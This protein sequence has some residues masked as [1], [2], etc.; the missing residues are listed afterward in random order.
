[1]KR[2]GGIQFLSLS[3]TNN[4]NILDETLIS[5]L[6]NLITSVDSSVPIVDASKIAPLFQINQ[7]Q[8][9]VFTFFIIIFSKT[10]KK[11]LLFKVWFNNKGWPA[12]VAFLNVF[13]NALLRGILLE[14]NSLNSLDDYGIT[15]IS[16]PLPETEFEIDTDL[17]SEIAIQLFTATCVIFAL[18][19]IPASFLVFLIDERVTTSK[20][21]QFVSGVKP[22][23]YWWANYLWDLTNYCVSITFCI[24]IFLAFSIEAYVY[25][26]NFLCLVLLLFL[27][28]FAIIPLMYPLSYLFK[29]PS[30]GFVL[31]SCVNIFIGIV[32][33]VATVTLQNFTDDQYLQ[34]V[35]SV[36]LK[37]FLIF[38]HYCLG[39]GLFDMSTIYATNTLSV[40]YG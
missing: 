39:R 16:H 38:P 22:L 26:I 10:K 25:Q 3:N 4:M 35:N 18:A 29:T 12:S 6:S 5:Q 27:Y 11:Q 20:H 30:T 19:F 24:F 32:T 34:N 15:A 13:N 28:G 1:M 33:T 31:V 14:N 37:V 17:Q 40:K 23:T 9:S 7:P 21:L 8:A 2:F 36:L